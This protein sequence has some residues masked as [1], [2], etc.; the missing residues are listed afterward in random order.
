MRTLSPARY[1]ASLSPEAEERVTRSLNRTRLGFDQDLVTPLVP[2][3]NAQVEGRQL[4]VEEVSRFAFSTGLDWLD[5]QERALSEKVGP[6]SIMLPYHERA[7][8]VETYFRQKTPVLDPDAW[9]YASNLTASLVGSTLHAT[10]IETAFRNMPR[11]T[12]LGG[13]FFSA[14]S[15]YYEAMLERARSILRSGFRDVLTDPCLLYWRGQSR[16][17]REAPKQRSV[18]GYPHYITVFELMIQEPL[19]NYLR[20][21][22]PAEFCA[23]IGSGAVD[24]AMTQL[25]GSEHGEILSVDFKGFDASVPGIV[26]ERVFGII[27]SWFSSRERDLIDYIQNAFLNIGLWT[28]DGILVGRDGGVPSGSG[29]TNMIDTLVQIFWGHYTAYVLRNQVLFHAT[30]GDDGVLLL[31]NPWSLEDLVDVSSNFG[32]EVSPDKGGVSAERVYYLQNIHSADY[33]V[34]GYNVGV[35]PLMKVLSGMLS[36]ERFHREWNSFDDSVRWWQQLESARFH[37][38]FPQMV[39]FLYDNDRYSREYNADQLI[40][41]AG[42]ME[43]VKSALDM[44]AFPY[45]KIPLPDLKSSAVAREMQKIGTQ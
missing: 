15:I 42:G 7:Q 19:L 33:Q 32:L 35:R 28:P 1:L 29:V 10:S 37:P 34:G 44:K 43:R 14:D 45:G 25:L 31:K 26:I 16:G 5:E 30:Q 3:R 8:Q 40:K 11:G 39:R 6:Y 20:A 22:R 41:K 4:R 23:W 24:S 36:Y 9:D 38:R 27:R 21:Y 12:N 13:P 17:P 18:W 2:D